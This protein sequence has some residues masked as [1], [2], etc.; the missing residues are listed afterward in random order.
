MTGLQNIQR[1]THV[2]LA[3]PNEGF[4][5]IAKNAHF[6][7]LHHA[8]NQDADV[9]FLQGAEAEPRATREECG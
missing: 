7:F 6:L 8:V 1:T 9:N 5:G 2:A 3:Q 4:G